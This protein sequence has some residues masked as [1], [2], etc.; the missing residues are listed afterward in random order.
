MS[1]IKAQDPLRFLKRI[2]RDLSPA[3]DRDST[4]KSQFNDV[5]KRASDILT[6]KH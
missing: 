5:K 2:K 4:G 6:N 1:G 3:K